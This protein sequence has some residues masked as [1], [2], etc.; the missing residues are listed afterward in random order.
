LESR[1]RD[2]KKRKQELENN[3]PVFEERDLEY[4]LQGKI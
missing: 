1:I 4:K 2:L 3:I